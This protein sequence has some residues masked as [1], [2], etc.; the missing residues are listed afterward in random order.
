ML[1]FISPTSV[2]IFIGRNR[3]VEGLD[4]VKISDLTIITT[5]GVGGFGRVELVRIHKYKIY[6]MYIH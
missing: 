2:I 6:I 4:E 1:N 3:S 5:L